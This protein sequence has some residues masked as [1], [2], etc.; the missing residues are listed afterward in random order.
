VVPA[1]AETGPA[2]DV[3]VESIVKT[4]ERCGV[5]ARRR[6]EIRARRRIE[7]GASRRVE[8]RIAA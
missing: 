6:I 1:R 7:I 4:L 2:H 3:A 5:V 8:N